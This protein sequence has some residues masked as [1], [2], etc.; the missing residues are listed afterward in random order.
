MTSRLE[1]AHQL[2]EDLIQGTDMLTPEERE[3]VER[4]QDI[5]HIAYAA[6]CA[7]VVYLIDMDRLRELHRKY[8]G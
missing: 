5:K 1:E 6:G 8:V 2:A 7:A 4:M 3:F